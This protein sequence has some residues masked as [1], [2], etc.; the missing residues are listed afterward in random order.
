MFGWYHA[1]DMTIFQQKEASFVNRDKV[2][3]YF[4]VRRLSNI[5]KTAD[6]KHNTI[7]LHDLWLG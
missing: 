7:H 4:S 5:I 6:Q 3:P 1:Y 2:R